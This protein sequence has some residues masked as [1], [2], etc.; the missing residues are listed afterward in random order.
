MV[1]PRPLAQH[2]DRLGRRQAARQPRHDRRR[3]G[4]AARDVALHP[5]GGD[6][7]RGPPLLFAFRYRPD[8]SGARD[9]DQCDAW[10]LHA[11]RFDAD[12]AVGQEPVPEAGPDAGAQGAGS[13]AGALAG[14]EAQQGPD[15][16][17]VSQ[18]G[19]FRLGRLWRRGSVAAL[20]RKIRARRLALGGGAA[21]RPAQGAVQAL[22]GARPEGR[23]GTRAAGSGGDARGEDDRRQGADH[24]DDRAGDPRRSLLD[25]LGELRRRPHHG[26]AAGPDRRGAQ[27]HHRRYRRST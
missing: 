19:L 14:A 1:D 21:R 23:R 9:G 22:A 26:R 6:G 3:G 18:P 17:N 5:A 7:D 27:R 8:R 24:R 20:F 16:R 11:G 10:R 4:R 25:G 2:Q 15:P 12:A 13:A